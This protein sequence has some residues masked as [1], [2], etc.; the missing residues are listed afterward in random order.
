MTFVKHT[1]QCD[2]CGLRYKR[3][4]DA[5]RWRTVVEHAPSGE[6]ISRLDMCS[7]PCWH[8]M[9]L[10]AAD[11]KVPDLPVRRPVSE[12]AAPGEVE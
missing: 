12:E 2:Y 8:E 6:V 10:L 7:K 11:Q 1:Y 3:K 9:H 4:E 5:P